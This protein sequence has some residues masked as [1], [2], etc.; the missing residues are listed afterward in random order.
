MI[1]QVPRLYS[2]E[3]DGINAELIEVEADLNVGLHSFNI[4]G[5]ADK[6]VSEAKERVNSALKNCGIKPPT[7]ENRR[8][9]INLAPADIKKIGSRFDLSI[10]LAYLLASDQLKRFD[11]EDKI[12]IGELSLDGTLRPVNGCLSITLLAKQKGIRQ[13]FVPE[14]N[15]VE[16]AAIPDVKVMPVRNLN[17]LIEH[18][19]NIKIIPKQPITMIEPGYPPSLVTL[20]EIKGQAAAKRALLVAAAGGHNMIMTGSPGTGKTMIA[21]AFASILPPPTI[22][23]S[24]EIT[25]IYSAAGL[26]FN[27]SFI[28]HRPFRAPHHSASRISIIGGGTNPKPGEISLAHRGVLFLDETPEF[29]R[30]VLEGLRQPLESGSVHVARVKKTLTFPARFMLVAAMNP[31]PCGYFDD[32]EKECRCTANE[33][34]RYQ[35]KVSGPLLDRIDIQLEV[36]RIPIEELRTKSTDDNIEKF[37]REQVMKA[38]LIQEKRFTHLKPKIFSNAEMSSKQVDGTVRLESGA[39]ELLKQTLERAFVS[40]RGYYRI[41]KVAQT[42][43][44]LAAASGQEISP[45][46]KKEHLAEAFQY[47][48]KNE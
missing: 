9:T 39:E 42:I 43:A 18:L 27:N 26:N 34:F 13:I 24:I 30:D 17:Q 46:V 44:D 20:G 40:A 4:V 37:M 41:L 22:E 5:L 29:H 19:E 12:F 11:T 23:E 3:L 35:K 2:A 45:T 36:P 10:A 28:N 8:I 38:R 16:A 47:R 14:A 48:L 6:A 25:R 21:Q 7:K 32:S 31:C 1:K 33:V 15:A